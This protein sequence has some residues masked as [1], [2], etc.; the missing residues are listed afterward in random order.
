MSQSTQAQL[1]GSSGR[2][3]FFGALLLVAL[4]V[5]ILLSTCRGSTG[6]YSMS[7]T[8]QGVLATLHLGNPL[9]LGEQITVEMR[10]FRTLVATGVGAALALSGALLQGVFRND[11]AAPSIIGVSSGA[12]LGATAAILILGGYGPLVML[13]SMAGFAPVFVTVAAFIGAAL[14][15]MLVMKLATSGGRVSIPSLLLIGIAINAI[16]GGILATIQSVILRDFEVAR[17]IITWSFGT[18]DD[19]TG[20]HVVLVLSGLALAALSIPFVSTE[21]D[22]LATGEEDARAL[23][24]NTRRVKLISLLAAALA[25]ASAVAVAGQIAF[26]GLVVPHILRLVTG[27]KHRTLLLL[28]L[29]AGPVFLLGCDLMQRTVLGRDYLRPGVLMSL[30]GG[31]FFLFLLVRN[32]NRIRAW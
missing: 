15:C 6:V 25:S 26:I 21:L 10:F 4:V 31:P 16:I 28:C 14:V 8:A 1:P 17:A 30:V 19:R 22:L 2:T 20:Y 5:L 12:S 27:R 32:R 18:L 13:Q 24:V 3:L 11:L 9:E 23:G 7:T 29:L